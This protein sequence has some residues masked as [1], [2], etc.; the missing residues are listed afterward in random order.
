MNLRLRFNQKN[1]KRDA[2][3]FHSAIGPI[4]RFSQCF[5]LLPIENVGNGDVTSLKFKWKSFKTILAMTL[6][7]LSTCESLLVVRSIFYGPIN[8]A[9]AGWCDNKIKKYKTL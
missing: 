8:L 6:L 5:G 3:S 1:L 9:Y 7:F 4:L 2:L